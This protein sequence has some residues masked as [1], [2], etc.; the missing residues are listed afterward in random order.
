[1]LW[2]Y[3][4]RKDGG[5]A[6]KTQR[7]VCDEFLAT[8]FVRTRAQCMSYVLSDDGA[9]RPAPAPRPHA[10]PLTDPALE[11]IAQLC[12]GIRTMSE[13]LREQK[14]GATLS[15]IDRA[16]LRLTTPL[17]PYLT[18]PSQATKPSPKAAGLPWT[19]KRRA[20]GRIEPPAVEG[21][22]I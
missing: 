3:L 15:A 13:I 20:L 18:A 14:V 22:R 21:G 4:R 2:F 6:R 17:F 19:V 10:P 11:R 5:Q 7:Q 1:M 12:D 9:Y 16:R 8:K